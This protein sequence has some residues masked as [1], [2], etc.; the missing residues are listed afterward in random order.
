[1]IG[2]PRT[3]ARPRR[4]I[5]LMLPPAAQRFFGAWETGLLPEN[6]GVARDRSHRKESAAWQFGRHNGCLRVKRLTACKGSL[7]T[8]EASSG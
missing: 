3:Q 7:A 5:V 1:M 8:A 2:V 4:R 6:D